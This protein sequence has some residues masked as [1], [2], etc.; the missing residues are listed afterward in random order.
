MLLVYC[1][2]NILYSTESNSIIFYYL[3][4]GNPV[5]LTVLGPSITQ[6]GDVLNEL[7]SC[8]ASIFTG[9]FPTCVATL[10]TSIGPQIAACIKQLL[11]NLQAINVDELLSAVNCLTGN[12]TDLSN[13][14][15]ALLAD[16]LTSLASL[17][18]QIS[19]VV[20]GL[21]TALTGAGGIL[22]G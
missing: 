21:L 12:L 7:F 3:Q 11:T 10:L 20:N 16:L 17:S 2:Y 4:A 14:V 8:L 1:I 19:T 9:P 6:L 13:Q 18:T 22:N 15:S 5:D